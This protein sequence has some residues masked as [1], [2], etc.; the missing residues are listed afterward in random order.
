MSGIVIRGVP[1]KG[2][3]LLQATLS[4]LFATALVWP[5]QPALA[6]FR[7]LGTSCH[8]LEEGYSVGPSGD[9]TTAIVG[10]AG[11]TPAY[12]CAYVY[13]VT[14]VAWSRQGCGEFADEISSG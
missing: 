1:S 3:S 5:W 10:T 12:Y 4:S 13:A 11:G 6:Q 2:G 9:G 14:S 8:G 7:L